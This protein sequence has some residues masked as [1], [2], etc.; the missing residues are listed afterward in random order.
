[1]KVLD[2]ISHQGNINHNHNKIQLPTLRMARIE[3]PDINKL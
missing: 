2:I 3:N 1:M